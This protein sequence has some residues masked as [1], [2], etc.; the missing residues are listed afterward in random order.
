MFLHKDLL[1]SLVVIGGLVVVVAT[2][3]FFTVPG[4]A[5]EPDAT[6]SGEA[7]SY[8]GTMTVTVG[9]TDDEIVAIDISHSDTPGVANPAI[10]TVPEN[11]LSEQSVDVDGKSGATV[12]SDAIREGAARALAAAGWDSDRIGME[13]S[14]DEPE[15]EA[16]DTY[17]ATADSYGGTMTVTVGITDGEIVM[18]EVEHD[19]T[20]GIANPAIDEIRRAVFESQS[21]DV[22]TVSGATQ[23]SRALISA[24]EEALDEAD[25]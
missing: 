21:A 19:D 3:I 6:Y 20:G 10:E 18:L 5:V 17:S 12:T 11:I 14:E 15:V 9:L 25:F 13:I 2:L 1:K 24:L 7:E 22:D 8:G 23:T 4:P 16:D